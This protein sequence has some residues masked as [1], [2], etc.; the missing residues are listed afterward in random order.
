M[1]LTRPLVLAL[2]GT[3]AA[4]AAQALDLH[5]C[6]ALGVSGLSLDGTIVGQGP[7]SLPRPEG[8]H[9]GAVLSG[10]GWSRFVTPV[11]D[12]SASMRPRFMID[13][14]AQPRALRRRNRVAVIAHRGEHFSH[15]ENTLAAFRAALGKGADFFEVDVRT[16][17]DGRLVLMHDSTVDR[18][19]NG[20]GRV[21]D[22]TFEQV[23]ALRAGGEM[24][25]TF[26]EALETARGRGQVYVD[27]KAVK[28]ADLVS[29]L[30]RERMLDRVVVYGPVP[31][32][33]EIRALRADVRIMP[34]SVSV[35]VV[36]RIVEEL[37][38]AVIAFS[39]GDWRDE[40]IRIARESGADIYVDRLGAADNPAAWQDAIDR[41]ATGI[42][43]DHPA[44]LVEYLRSKGLHE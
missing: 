32:L 33:Q 22:M 14:A 8:E 25:P 28:A 3:A 42:Q 2:L 16:T 21:A 34:E 23:R 40:I 11:E 26:E 18:T 12:A 31:F 43:T 9:R 36:R 10:S 38:P 6:G 44:R 39:A 37:R 13:G 20:R 7:R 15:P 24:V 29:A 1:L 5:L 41:G 4:P 27:C 19:T 35:E 30:E 17:A